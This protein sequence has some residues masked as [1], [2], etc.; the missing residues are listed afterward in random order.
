MVHSDMAFNSILY[1]ERPPSGVEL[2]EQPDFFRDLNLDQIV[3][4]VLADWKEYGLKCFFYSP[5]HDLEDVTYRQEVMQDFG[6]PLV[7][8]AIMSF[9]GQMRRMRS[10][11]KDGRKLY[12]KRFVDRSFLGA[13]S[14][15]CSAIRE[16]SVELAGVTITSCGLKAFREY[17]NEYVNSSSFAT[18]T[19]E[20][21]QLRSELSAIRYCM[22]IGDGGITVRHYGGETDYSCTVEAIFAKFRGGAGAE[23]RV[24]LPNTE[25]ANHIE[26][27]VLD[28]VALLFPEVF[29]T[30]GEFCTSKSAFVDETVERFDREIH[31]YIAY[32]KHLEPL[33]QAGL[34][35]CLPTVSKTKRVDVR[36]ACDLALAGKLLTEKR[37][38]VPN[39]FRLNDEERV[40]V[41]TGPNQGGK[42]TFARMFGQLHYLASLGCPVPASEAR[43]VLFDQMFT[44]FERREATGDLRGKLQDDLVR[45][46]Q[47]LEGATAAS[48]IILNEI[49]SSTTVHD[50]LFLGKQILQHVTERDAVGVCVTFLDELSTLNDKMVSVVS[51][52][53]PEDPTIRT[54]K[55]ERRPADG[56]AYAIAIAE[57]HRV[58]YRHIR[59]RLGV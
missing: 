15:Y 9:T 28:R 21:E 38:V 50:A 44:H 12:Y 11:L 40:F 51:N 22:L 35:F 2:I 34:T 54:Y 49:F 19:N 6:S 20:T 53:D 46:H 16:L 33:A 32:L 14:I 13:V 58:T 47:T 7:M 59:E 37:A 55:L 52:V 8:Q 36:C 4:A 5:L 10:H 25:R 23:H 56:L 39:D 43:L 30:L 31:F 26:A 48:I 41:V 18:L 24:R 45:V 1:R 29:R 3:E 17:L 57:K 27:G 42:T